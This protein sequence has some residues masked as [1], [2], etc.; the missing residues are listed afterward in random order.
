MSDRR[1][2]PGRPALPPDQRKETSPV[3]TRVSLEIFDK[4]ARQAAKRDLTISAFL[5]KLI[6]RYFR[7][8]SS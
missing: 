2:R 1:K 4:I 5:R 6:E 8:N 3:N 7:T